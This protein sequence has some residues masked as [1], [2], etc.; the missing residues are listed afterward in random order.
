VEKLKLKIYILGSLLTGV[1]VAVSGIIGFVGL[2]IPHIV[3]LILGADHRFVLPSA[4]LCGASFLILADTVSRTIIAPMELP[5]GVITAFCG[6]PF[7]IY[8]LKTK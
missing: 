8:L 2:I 3:R 1:S 5:V 4:F 6:A 7:F